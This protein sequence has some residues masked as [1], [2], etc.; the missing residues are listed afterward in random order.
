MPLVVA[1]L[2]VVLAVPAFAATPRI[3][4]ERVI[5]APYSL[6]EAERATVIY[7]IGDN[8]KIATFLEALVTDT[9]EARLRIDDATRHQ[10]HFLAERVEPA[11]IRGLQRQY[12]SDAYLG[13]KAFTC[14]NE[15]RGGEGSVHD[16][17]GKRQR[18]RVVWVEATCSARVD[19][20]DAK[21]LAKRF[22]FVARGEGK[23]SRV[24][25]LSRDVRDAALENAARRAAIN[26]AESI[27]PRR[28]RESIALDD[29][30]PLFD[31]GM[32]MIDAERFAEARAIWDRALRQY[33]DSAALH[34]NLAAVSE[35][36]GDVEAARRHLN[37]A[38]RLAPEETRYRAGFEMFL[39]RHSI[40]P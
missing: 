1:A 12:P 19:V 6:G 36:I 7:A 39:R 24:A 23:S 33:G 16:Q 20:L 14:T 34:Y 31:E 21:T 28:V 8:D 29:S 10:Q 30:A 22:S 35:A 11:T 9:A 25:E 13:V 15:L 3:V 18:Q 27:T 32:S 5:P 4:F 26:A 40:R 2:L 17:D 38:R 37:E